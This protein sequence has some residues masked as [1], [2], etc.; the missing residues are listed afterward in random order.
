MN[1]VMVNLLLGI[2]SLVGGNS[3]LNASSILSNS[4]EVSLKTVSHLLEIANEISYSGL[5]WEY[6]FRNIDHGIG[7]LREELRLSITR[8]MD[9]FEGQLLWAVATQLGG[10]YKQGGCDWSEQKICISAFAHRD[11]IQ[12]RSLSVFY[13]PGEP[14]EVES[15]FCF[16]DGKTLEAT[17]RLKT[18]FEIDRQLARSLFL[19][20]LRRGDDSYA[21]MLLRKAAEEFVPA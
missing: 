18:V 5:K 1:A 14:L 15:E 7:G 9:Q 17:E 20:S 12:S 19:D 4:A 16:V 2:N 21:E 11:R 13:L 10:P 3:L 8:R 6:D